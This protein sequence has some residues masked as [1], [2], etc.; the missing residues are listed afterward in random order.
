MELYRIV[1]AKWAN[2]LI[3]SG[4]AARWNSNG[5]F[6][7][8]SSFSRSLACLENI[9]HHSGLD[10]TASFNVMVLSAPDDIA[11]HEIPVTMLPPNWHLSDPLTYNRCGQVG[12]D[13][14]KRKDT[15]LLKLPSAIIKNEFNCLINAMHPDFS[16]I[17]LLDV[18][19]FFFDPRIKKL[20]C[21]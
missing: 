15:V 3:A 19:P 5:V 1:L 21:N 12:D 9:V 7:I 6:V 17:K 8:Y 4:R 10:L 16:R 2:G 13:W 18:E 11:I 14:Y 20:A